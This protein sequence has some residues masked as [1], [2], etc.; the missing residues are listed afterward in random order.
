MPRKWTNLNL[1]G[2]IIR[3]GKTVSRHFRYTA[4]GWSGRR[5]ITSITIRFVPSWRDRPKTTSG[6]ASELTTMILRSHCRCIVIGGARGWWEAER[7]NEE[8]GLAGAF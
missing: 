8:D 6:P 5:W 7:I 2:A 4:D 3:C 1:P